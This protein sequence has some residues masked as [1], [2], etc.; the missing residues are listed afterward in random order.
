MFEPDVVEDGE[1][2]YET[3]RW[4]VDGEE[5]GDP[6]AGGHSL[7]SRTVGGKPPFVSLSMI[8]EGLSP[9]GLGGSAASMGREAESKEDGDGGRPLSP[10]VRLTKRGKPAK[11]VGFSA[12]DRIVLIPARA[13]YD[14]LTKSLLWWSLSDYEAFKQATLADYQVRRCCLVSSCRRVL[15][16]SRRRFGIGGLDLSRA[17]LSTSSSN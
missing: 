5:K 14:D 3:V 7:V 8:G 10:V 12:T 2:D 4:S 1:Q 17:R 13:D 11:Q 15:L 9:V 6:P 16:L